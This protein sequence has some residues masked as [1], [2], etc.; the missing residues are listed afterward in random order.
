MKQITIS[1]VFIF[2]VFI[3]SCSKDS[4]NEEKKDPVSVLSSSEIQGTWS[5]KYEGKII[6]TF[7]GDEY[8]Y[9]LLWGN[10]WQLKEHGTFNLNNGV[11]TFSQI[12]EIIGY[13]MPGREY[14]ETIQWWNKNKK[15]LIIDGVAYNR[16]NK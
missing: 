9:E 8:K 12:Q 2:S 16:T 3:A 6:Y 4:E 1:L 14:S 7:N 11:I 13:T 5:E 10:E 15:D